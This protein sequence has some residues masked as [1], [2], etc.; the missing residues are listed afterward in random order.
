MIIIG[1]TGT[2]GAGKGTVVD[3]LVN[4]NGFA[5]YHA[6]ALLLAEIERQGLPPTR[7]SM[8]I[9]GNYLRSQHG[10]DYVVTHF[11]AQAKETGDQKIAIDSLRTIAEATTL[12]AHGGILLA[13]D[14]DQH[15]RYE[16][17]QARRSSSDQ[18]TFEQFKEQEDLEN[19]DPDPHGMQKRKVIAMADY[20]I[21]NDGT[22]EALHQKIDEVLTRI[23]A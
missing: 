17:V 11:L 16:R 4:Q 10:N 12:K 15:L 8:R 23:E 20:V 19:N 1:V 13:V 18:V 5:L 22:L 2:D 14:A 21:Q 3:Y 9:A 7:A 6:R